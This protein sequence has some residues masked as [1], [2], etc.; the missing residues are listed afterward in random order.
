MYRIEC[1]VAGTI[2]D[3]GV[4]LLLGVYLS[5]SPTA[6]RSVPRVSSFGC[7]VSIYASKIEVIIIL[8]HG[9]QF[10]SDGGWAFRA[11]DDTIPCSNSLFMYVPRSVV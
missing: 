8:I 11:R 2:D 5:P 9:A 10:R 6:S 4:V 7:T 3:S 1:K